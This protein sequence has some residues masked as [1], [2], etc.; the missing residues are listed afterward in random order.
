MAREFTCRQF[1]DL[2]WSMPITQVA[3]DFALSDVAGHNIRRKAPR[4]DASAQ[5]VG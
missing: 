5:V 2:V 3:K 1:Y 4:R